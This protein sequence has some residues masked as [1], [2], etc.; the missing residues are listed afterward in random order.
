MTQM[1]TLWP[2]QDDGAAEFAAQFY[3]SLE[4]HAPA[5]ALA[6]AQR[7]MLAHEHYRLPYYW[8]A[9]QLAGSN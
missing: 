9:Y 5:G 2:V 6:A 4:T 7:F 8:A 1:A 3:A